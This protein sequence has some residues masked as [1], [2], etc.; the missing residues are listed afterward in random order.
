M[1]PLSEI[2][3]LAFLAGYRQVRDLTGTELGW[4]PLFVAA[5][6]AATL[7]RLRAALDVPPSPADPAW[8]VPLRG[9]LVA[10]TAA[11][12]TTAV[13]FGG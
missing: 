13:S 7:T 11:L 6:A 2:A 12:R 9:R 5:H 8:L 10:H 1:L 4:T 3:G